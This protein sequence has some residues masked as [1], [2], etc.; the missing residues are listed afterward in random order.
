VQAFVQGAIIE[1]FINDRFA[2]T[3]RAYDYSKGCLSLET[4]GG[5]MEILDLA[6]RTLP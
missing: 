1:C 4:E 5:Q 6:V 3:C 2:F